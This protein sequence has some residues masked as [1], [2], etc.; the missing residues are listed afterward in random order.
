LCNKNAPF[1]KKNGE[2]F[3]ESHH[4]KPRA[5]GGSDTIDNV[6]ALCPNCHRKIHHFK[7]SSDIAQIKQIAID[8]YNKCL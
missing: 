4:I 6:S 7:K 2:P 8:R 5:E 3:L 1:I